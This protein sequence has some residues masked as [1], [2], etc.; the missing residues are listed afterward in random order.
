[1][2]VEIWY[3]ITCC[4]VVYQRAAA[5]FVLLVLLEVKTMLSHLTEKCTAPNF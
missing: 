3:E 4:T 2:W 5:Q 1:M